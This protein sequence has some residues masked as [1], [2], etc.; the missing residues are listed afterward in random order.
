MQLMFY[1]V[2][3]SWSFIVLCNMFI[4][5]TFLS[6]FLSTYLFFDL[7]SL[8]H[9]ITVFFLPTF[10]AIICPPRSYYC[11]QLDKY[12]VFFPRLLIMSRA[13]KWLHKLANTWMPIEGN[14]GSLFDLLDFLEVI[15]LLAALLSIHSTTL[16]QGGLAASS[17]SPQC[18]WVLLNLL[19]MWWVCICVQWK[20]QFGFLARVGL[21]QVILC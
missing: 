13:P 12:N 14:C 7:T 6:L 2:S 1:A 20:L 10:P 18:G 19:W 4:K 16:K 11:S 15:L 3:F 17:S 21:S 8:H 5:L 9:P